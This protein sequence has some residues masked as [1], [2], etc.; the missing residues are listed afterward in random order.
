MFVWDFLQINIQ[1]GMECYIVEK[2]VFHQK[3][4]S[5]LMDLK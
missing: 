4:L 2:E 5:R 3:T 1:N